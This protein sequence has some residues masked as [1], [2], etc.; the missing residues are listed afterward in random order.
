LS[1]QFLPCGGLAD[2]AGGAAGI[3]FA[4]HLHFG[5]NLPRIS[6]AAD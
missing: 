4:Q 1:F 5:I 2:G 6:H 3:T